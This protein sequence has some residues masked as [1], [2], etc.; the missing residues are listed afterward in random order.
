M[1]VSSPAATGSAG[2]AFETKVAAGCLTIL[3]TGGA[4]LCLGTGTLRL[5]HLQA[6]HLGWRTDDL[7]LEAT[8]SA[9]APMKAALQVKRSFALSETDEDCV[10]TLRN[11]LADFRNAALFDQQRDFLGLVTSSLSAKLARGFRTLL[12]CAR[13]SINAADMARRLAIPGYLGKPA[14]EYYKTIRTIFAG[15][16]GE[17]ASDDELWQFLRCYQAI[18]LDLNVAGGFAETMLRSLLVATLPDGNRAA[19]DTTWN[20]LIVLALADAGSARSLTRETLPQALLRLHTKAT[21]F[22][23]GISRLLEDSAVVADG[24]DTAIADK[25]A[26]PRRELSGELCRL[27]E[28]SQLIFV[29][30]AA[31]SGKSALVKSVIPV[32]TRGGVGFAFR[33][34]SLA[35]HHINEVLHRFEL[36]LDA[37]QAQT[38]M[39]GKKVLWVDS[40]ER[41]MEKPPELRV[42]FLDLLRALKNDPTWRLI[43]TCRDYSAETVR[44]AL[45]GEVGMVAEDVE[46]GELDDSELNEVI[47]DFPSL[48]LPLSNP[49]LRSLLR[50][51]FFLDKAAKMNWDAAEPL[52]T[53]ERAFREKVWNEVVRRVDEDM[54]SGLPKLRGQVLIEIALR[55]A[56]ALE[57]FVSAA[58]LDSRAL[59]RLVRD[60]ILQTPSTGSDLYAPAHDVFEDW[61]LMRWLDEAFVRHERQLD[62]LLRELGT[63]PALRRAYRRWLTECL[64]ID[65]K[66]TDSMVVGLIQ[67]QHVAAHWREDTLVGVLQSRDALGFLDRNKAM[68]LA[69]DARL[70]RQVIHILRVACRAAIPRRMFGV[71]SAGEF[72]LPK[73]NGWIG[74]GLQMEMATPLFTE[75]DLLLIVGFLEDWMLLTRYGLQYPEGASSIANIAWHWLPKIPWRSPVCDAEERLLRVILAIPLAAEPTLTTKVEEALK[76]ERPGR[77]D[78]ELLKLIFNHFACDAIF[79][80]MPDLGFR[81]A[82]H[83]LDLNRDIEE[84]IADRS[85]YSSQAVNEAFGLGG[86]FDMDD[87]PSSAFN[88]PYLRMLWHHPARGVDFI[89]RLINR[90]CEAFAHPDNR[91]EFIEPPGTVLLELPDGPHE[92]FGNWRL[93]AAYR[94]M[95]VTPNTFE[96]A[97]MALEHW[98]L[99]KVQRKDSDLE[100]ILLDLLQRTNNVAISAIVASIAAAAPSLAGEAAYALL[101]FPSL[102]R[103]DL[104]R[105]TQESFMSAQLGGFGLPQIS[106]EKGLY[107]K[108]RKES[109]KREHRG[110]NLEH[111]AVMLQMTDRFR[112]RVWKLIDQYKSKLPP[113][114]DQDTKLWRIQL[115]RIDARN[116]VEAGRTEE[117]HV[118][119]TSSEPEADLQAIIEEQKPRSAAL[120]TA[121]SLLNWGMSAFNGKSASD[122]WK[123]RLGKAQEY[124]GARE[125][126]SDEQGLPTGGPVY[127]AAVCVRD[128]WTEMSPEEQDWCAHTV[129]DA[130][131]ADADNADYFSVAARNSMEGSRP[132]AF[133]LSALFGKALLPETQ[134]RLLPTLAKAIIHA[135]EETVDYAMQGVGRFLWSLDRALGLTCVQ[136]LVTITMERDAFMERQRGISF[137]ER[138][139]EEAFNS[140]LGSRLREFISGRQA[141]DE[142]QIARLNI[143]AWPGRAV[144]KY[145]FGIATLNPDDRLM[146]QVMQRSAA[147]LPAMWQADARGHRSRREV[148]AEE[149]YDPQL[150]HDFVDAVCRFALQLESAD[151]LV[152]LDPVFVAAPTFPEKAS[153]VVTWL[154]LH[155]GDRAPA[156][157]LWTLWQR[158]ADDFAATVNPEQVDGEH[159]GEAKM[160]HELF[161]G[162]NWGDQ[163]NWLPLH[164]ET[165]RLREF[166]L[167][168]PSTEQ[169]FECYAYYLAKAGTPTLPDALTDIAAKLQNSTPLGHLNDTAVYYLEEVLTRLIYGGNS[170]IRI[171]SDLRGAVL[172]I[173]DALVA[174]GSSPAYKL[175]DDFLTPISVI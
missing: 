103:V 120:D 50:N 128:H 29:T 99:E 45:F 32:V 70:L 24:V 76:D 101:T 19:A 15:A 132:A 80:D 25:T 164:G 53:T 75:A 139:P 16:D 151:G 89:L 153:S 33:A 172:T 86:R 23:H 20:E 146:R 126:A 67:N 102:L 171:E 18:D 162:H 10:Q 28:T 111:V 122:D 108:E 114:Q 113:E 92:Q 152:F 131:D 17:S 73:G 40:L 168:L 43:V 72:F 110:R 125:I 58:E 52:P 133:V 95:N 130:V 57:P 61:T 144:A 134:A 64:D 100:S 82:E 157:T 118:L 34:V 27:V 117:G 147:L 123:D 175:R 74:V 161:L 96:S 163:R 4:P 22:S 149:Q 97:L 44:T 2:S 1:A 13:A 71:D 69:H 109:A 12:D 160:L 98:L 121:I 21:G 129:C 106:A 77:S 3:L 124:L 174:A 142:D 112:D 85:D 159:S 5:V 63:F 173:L 169:G 7:L 107:D 91:Y 105:S 88:G 8:N 119:I 135:A 62:P 51:P 81:V 55:R 39:H 79:R 138:E 66:T 38:A 170:R 65:P 116:F 11:A 93:W 165:K 31:G 167:R 14:F 35:G 41:L 94:G 90:A 145:L 143:A 158:F 6:G 9:G 47:I 87:F 140:I 150:E 30:G 36:S 48:G 166:F 104:D 26:I 137:T 37:L 60:S 56:K 148:E 83:A 68:L 46:I 136:A 54:E 141:A 154:I 84:V 59:G 49:S 78:R 42:A 127:V 156:P 115:H 155:Q